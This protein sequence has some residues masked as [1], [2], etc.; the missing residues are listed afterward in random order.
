[1]EASGFDESEVTFKIG[2]VHR[3]PR[4][5]TSR[6]ARSPSSGT[7]SS[8]ARRLAR[9]PTASAAADSGATAPSVAATSEA[10]TRL[11]ASPLTDRS[12]NVPRVGSASAKK[13]SLTRRSPSASATRPGPVRATEGVA[14]DDE[15]VARFSQAEL[16]T[17]VRLAVAAVEAQHAEA[18]ASLRRDVLDARA[19]HGPSA[20]EV[21]P[22]W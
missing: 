13:G 14:V 15:H 12:V 22:A 5:P 20:V 1:M 18:M 11:F 8:S 2:G 10:R 21:R 4:T 6:V 7:L 3:A 16:D 9:T 19:G 17:R